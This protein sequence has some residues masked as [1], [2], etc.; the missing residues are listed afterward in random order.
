MQFK[1]D[2]REVHVL[3]QFKLDSI[4]GDKWLIFH[5]TNDVYITGYW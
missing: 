2:K 1:L 3:E 5:T 4:K